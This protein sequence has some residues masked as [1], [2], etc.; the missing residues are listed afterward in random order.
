MGLLKNGNNPL[1]SPS[2]PRRDVFRVFGS[3]V[4]LT[5]VGLLLPG[6]DGSDSSGSTG[7]TGLLGNVS[8]EIGADEIAHVRFL[9]TAITNAGGQP[10]ARPAL[11]LDALGAVTNETTFLTVSRAFEDVGVSAYGGA[12]RLITDKNV[13]EAAGRIL[14]TEAYHAGN[15]RYQAVSRGLSVTAIDAKDQPPNNT[16]FFPTDTNG[17]SVIRSVAEVLAVAGAF[18]PNGINGTTTPATDV[19]ILNFA[20]NLEYLEAEFYSYV[21]SGA[22]LDAADTSGQGTLGTTTGAPTFRA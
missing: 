15:L 20:L 9:R 3:G 5:A 21:N 2:V 12:A 1:T 8:R 7:S 19:E 6:C 13:L 14:A 17:L 4:A 10:I 16:N 11:K 22:G 18:F